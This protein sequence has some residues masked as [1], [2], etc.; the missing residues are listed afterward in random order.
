MLAA[1]EAEEIHGDPVSSFDREEPIVTM[2]QFDKHMEARRA[3]INCS[4]IQCCQ[5]DRNA[6]W[7]AERERKALLA[8]GRQG[9]NVEGRVNRGGSA[10]MAR[11][12]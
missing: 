9:V 10:A 1:I 8:R 5:A 7:N 3:E 11:D 12:Y 4:P 2:D 6:I